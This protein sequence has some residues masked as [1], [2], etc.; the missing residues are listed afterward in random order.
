MHSAT[1]G[2]RIFEAIWAHEWIL[3]YYISSAIL[4]KLG[5]LLVL[6]G[7]I[8]FQ[9]PHCLG[10]GLSLPLLGLEPCIAAPR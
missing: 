9:L 4:A 8:S 5:A 10:V 2:P 3:P 6:G 7:G 1:L